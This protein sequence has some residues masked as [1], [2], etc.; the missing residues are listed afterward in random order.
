MSKNEL[1][2]I[3][4]GTVIEALPSTM[5]RVKVDDTIILSH[6]AGK[7]RIHYIKV[8]PGDKVS[9]KLSPDGNRGIIIKRETSFVRK[10]TR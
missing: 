7:M 5:F 3:V 6:L 10:P 2:K 1:E 4:Q 8:M 9:L